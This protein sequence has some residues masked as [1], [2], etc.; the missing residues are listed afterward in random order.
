M[1]FSELITYFDKQYAYIEITVENPQIFSV[2]DY[3]EVLDKNTF[4]SVIKKDEYDECL[5][6]G[7]FKTEQYK[8][9]FNTFS[10]KPKVC[11]VQSI[12][13]S[14]LYILVI[15]N[16]S[17]KHA[18][19]FDENG[20][21]IALTDDVIKDS[22]VRDV[23]SLINNNYK[24]ILNN[25]SCYLLGK[26]VGSNT[27]DNSFILIDASRS[28][29]FSVVTKRFSEIG[30]SEY[31]QD[32]LAYVIAAPE[33][34]LTNIDDYGFILYDS[35][36]TITDKTSATRASEMTKAMVSSQGDKYVRLWD[37]YT[38][39]Q[40]KIE[41]DRRNNAGT[42]EFTHYQ[43]IG[44]K[45]RF[46][47]KNAHDVERFFK[48]AATN[49]GDIS[50]AISQG[51]YTYIAANMR[52][53]YYS[54]SGFVEC[55]SDEGAEVF[56]ALSSK[57]GGNIQLNIAGTKVMYERRKK[58]IKAIQEAKSANPQIA[59][60]LE[61]KYGDIQSRDSEKIEIDDKIIKDVYKQFSP[62][63]SQ[64][65]AIEAALNTPDIMIIQGPPG[66]GKT[67]VI[68]AIRAHLQAKNK[69]VDII[70]DKY[71]LTAYQ[72][73]AT[74]NMAKGEYDE[75]GFPI[76]AQVGGVHKRDLSVIEWSRR[77]IEQIEDENPDLTTYTDK[78]E[79][80]VFLKTLMNDFQN[81]CKLSDAIS[82]LKMICDKIAKSDLTDADKTK[83]H[84]H[85][86]I[87]RLEAKYAAEEDVLMNYYA[88]IIPSTQAALDDDGITLIKKIIKY[89]RDRYMMFEQIAS[90]ITNLENIISA[91]VIDIKQLRKIKTDL[92]IENERINLL[93]KEDA[94]KINKELSAVVNEVKKYRSSDKQEI[95]SDYLSALYSTDEVATVIKQYQ[96]V[97]AA[98]HQQSAPSEDII[99]NDVI[100]DEAARSCPPDLLIPL[101]LCKKRVILVGDHKQLPQFIEDDV[102]KEIVT[103]ATENEL[104]EQKDETSIREKYKIST[105]EYMLDK[106]KELQKSDPAHNRVVSLNKQYRMPDII[107]S[108]VSKHFYDNKLENSG[109]PTEHFEQNYDGIGG[110]NML[111]VDAAKVGSSESK[112][113]SGSWTRK[114]E[115]EIIVDYIENIIS[116]SKW[117][118]KRNKDGEVQRDEIGV[119]TFYA[120]QRD[121]I[122]KLI[123][124]R[125]DEKYHSYIDVGTVDSFQG[126]EFPIVFLS[127]VR[128][129]KSNKYGFLVN[130]NRLCVALSRA[131][132]CMVIVGNSDMMKSGVAV[133]N[134]PAL[135]DVYE[136]CLSRTGGV[137]DVA[138]QYSIS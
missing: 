76:V 47:I 125:I 1:K 81:K 133:E 37:E 31:T 48:Y 126:K 113:A 42:I 26:H 107:G 18:R 29:Y 96:Q 85:F 16:L 13:E 130:K 100:V 4:V 25:K 33:K 112:S 72:R 24:L 12:N 134:V 89:Y 64:Q 98:T 95:I 136:T 19:D 99:Y 132:K 103:S 9:M 88:K 120:A 137:C 28:K 138:T 50:I 117:L 35:E 60:L 67:K 65:A 121:L 5:S 92:L 41:V 11:Q 110:L 90:C 83:D 123:D 46:Y 77:K 78:K 118:T 80:V 70:D 15:Y 91:D 10:K 36:I 61:G 45:Y 63:L 38:E 115:A 102:L 20:L 51:E 54:G 74:Q 116:D 49:G 128:S 97:V 59:C 32:D 106:V 122:M 52:E 27:K 66:T 40:Y 79:I 94:E 105:F 43:S 53:S 14:T 69:D 62:N 2:G 21:S 127:L 75:L 119:I 135:V 17:V 34:P 30:I 68:K 7:S 111:W 82:K 39:K 73:D 44:N 131:Q 84:L 23:E 71:L 87:K 104:F 3:V 114:C 93:S 22:S 57:R 58:A 101:S 8:N 124:E 56:D 55:Y 86:L 6:D 129:N 109:L 108:L